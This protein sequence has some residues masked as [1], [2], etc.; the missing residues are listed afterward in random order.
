MRGVHWCDRGCL[1]KSTSSLTNYSLFS[2]AKE[3]GDSEIRFEWKS[4]ECRYPSFLSKF[5]LL[6]HLPFPLTSVQTVIMHTQTFNRSLAKALHTAISQTSCLMAHYPRLTRLK[7][8]NNS[9]LQYTPTSGHAHNRA[10]VRAVLK[11]H[12]L[13]LRRVYLQIER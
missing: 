6:L 2:F 5:N 4:L 13:A 10:P 3:Q 9:P 7:Q 1:V 8:L 12:A 11:Q